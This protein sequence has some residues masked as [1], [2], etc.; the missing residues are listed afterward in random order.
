MGIR[1][2]VF[3]GH[4]RLTLKGDEHIFE[5][6]TG[7]RMNLVAAWGAITNHNANTWARY[8]AVPDFISRGSSASGGA[9][10]GHTSLNACSDI[11]KCNPANDSLPLWAARQFWVGGPHEIQSEMCSLLR[12][13]HPKGSLNIYEQQKANLNLL[14]PS[15]VQPLSHAKVRALDFRPASGVTE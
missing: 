9:V 7:D 3:F 4:D 5:H 2:N 14:Q 6:N 11:S 1:N 13:C 15:L 10:P 8:N 12:S